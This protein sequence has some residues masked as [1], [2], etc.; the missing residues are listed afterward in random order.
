M[1]S[2]IQRTERNDSSS[3][4][5]STDPDLFAAHQE[6]IAS[7][8]KEYNKYLDDQVE[9]VGHLDRR[10][11]EREK[12]RTHLNIASDFHSGLLEVQRAA[13]DQVSAFSLAQSGA[14]DLTPGHTE[15]Y[16]AALERVGSINPTD[17][18]DRFSLDDKKS[19]INDLS[20]TLAL[21]E[22][23]PAAKGMQLIRI[24]GLQDEVP[25][26]EHHIELFGHP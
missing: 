12:L 6:L 9:V 4:L 5:R 15:A 17:W 11:T 3:F 16:S 14:R 18:Q 2:A 1:K 13:T 25:H 23:P 21:S 10:V 7:G 24:R 8:C 26:A 19:T 20:T 22:D